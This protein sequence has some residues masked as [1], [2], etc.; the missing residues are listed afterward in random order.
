VRDTYDFVRSF[1]TFKL[2]RLALRA[3]FLKGLTYNLDF[4]DLLDNYTHR[5]AE[6]KWIR[7]YMLQA[8]YTYLGPTKT[9]DGLQVD[10]AAHKI[11]RYP[12]G[13]T[14]TERFNLDAELVRPVGVYTG[15][16]EAYRRL[17][18]GR[19]IDYYRGTRTRV[20]FL[21]LPRGPVVRPYPTNARSSV[22]REFAARGQAILL[23]EHSFDQMEQPAFFMDPVHFNEAGGERFAELLS[24]AVGA[25]LGHPRKAGA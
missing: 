8:R 10:W 18:F 24:R 22:V 16:R 15:Q 17:W 4:Q 21:R 9:V 11:T 7:E 13:A 12:P 5:M 1:P 20:I 19:I 25:A 3:I 2:R 23:D 14:E 6:L